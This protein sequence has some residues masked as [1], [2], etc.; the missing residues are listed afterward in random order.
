MCPLDEATAC[1]HKAKEESTIDGSKE[2]SLP[3]KSFKERMGTFSLVI[4]FLC[5]MITL[6]TICFLGW[7]WWGDRS[8]GY[9]R[10]IVLGDHLKQAI[11]LASL[12]I[13]LPASVLAT[14]VTSMIA[15]IAIERHGV[16]LK[17]LASVSVVRFSNSGQ[18]P[19]LWNL[20]LDMHF[21]KWP[22]LPILIIPVWITITGIQF[23]ST[24]LL[25][26]LAQG[27]VGGI[28]TTAINASGLSY[29]SFFID[30]EVNPG[31]PLFFTPDYWIGSL[32]GFETFAEYS[33]PASSVEGLDDTGLTLRSFLPIGDQN[34][35]ETLQAFQGLASVFDLRVVCARPT[36]LG[37]SICGSNPLLFCGNFTIDVPVPDLVGF[38]GLVKFESKLPAQYG[39]PD[40]SK[41]V[42]WEMYFLD[43]IYGGRI[44]SLD[45]TNN[46]T[47]Q[48]T[49][50]P[51]LN[52]TSA[53]SVSLQQDS[54]W[55]ADN[56]NSQW[57][58]TLGHSYIVMNASQPVSVLPIG[59]LNF[60][61]T[62]SG[63]WTQVNF[64][65]SNSS[66]SFSLS[67]CYDS[68]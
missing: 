53:P 23:C 13:T 32:I 63:P 3:H 49:W 34:S 46:Q 7:L 37:L 61:S 4:S 28:S 12:L 5:P 24:L 55:V 45:P 68:L 52:Y 64:S 54:C 10:R 16:S 40:Q 38:D 21:F 11:P 26:D 17:H 36:L 50:N 15:S 30:G 60:T 66:Q 19:T 20:L 41:G 1:V 9:W 51:N 6:I 31:S 48:H 65:S 2:R 18:P 58:V 43:T 22:A 57:G 42:P 29:S 14:H 25:S 62:L 27:F 39:Q 8:N 44:A 47:L 59:Q 33:Q 56:G 67:V 35:R